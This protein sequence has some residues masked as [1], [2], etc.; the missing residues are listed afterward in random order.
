MS[1]SGQVNWV[2]VRHAYCEG[3]QSLVEICRQYGLTNRQLRYRREKEGWPPRQSGQP[4]QK[5][6]SDTSPQRQIARLYRLLDRLMNEI[7]ALPD[8]ADT[9]KGAPEMSSA[10]RERSAR[11]LSSVIRSFEK[12][13]E[14]E[15]EE[16]SQNQTQS[17]DELNEE[18]NRAKAFREILRE[19]L[20]KLTN[21][22]N[23]DEVS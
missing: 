22:R 1:N 20:A 16:L 10:D 21:A 9:E 17:N 7:E 11:T 14:L 18:K 4:S 19:R 8:H 6:T 12:I 5:S 2:A 3:K 13:K 23:A 15:A